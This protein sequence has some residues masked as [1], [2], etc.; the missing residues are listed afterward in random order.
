MEIPIKTNQQIELMKQGGSKLSQILFSL[1]KMVKVG[2]NIVDIE[3]KAN[4]LIRKAGGQPA[5]KRVPGYH[6]ATCININDGIVHGIPKD[7]LIKDQD[8]VSIDIGMFYQGFNTDMCYAFQVGSHDQATTD[9]LKA[10][11][12]A[13]TAVN[14]LAKPLNYIGHLSQKTQEIIEGH[15][16]NCARSLTGHGV[17]LKLHEPP[18]IPCF[19]NGEVSQTPMIKA[20]MTLAI[21]IIYTQGEPDLVVDDQDKWTIRTKDGKMATVFENTIAVLENGPLVLTPLPN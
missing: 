7:Y 20:G 10:G 8:L 6:W 9:F 11:K 4:Q 1:V 19:L 17:G 16:Y 5:F 3:A 12:K 2:T 18:S 14:A 13:L 21:E 15:G